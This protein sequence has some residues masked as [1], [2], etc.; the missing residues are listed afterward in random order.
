MN[1][2]KFVQLKSFGGRLLFLFT[3]LVL[4]IS[5]VF[6]EV[7]ES[8]FGAIRE[9]PTDTDPIGVG[10]EPPPYEAPAG[11]FTWSMEKR[12]GV[13]RDRDGMIDYHWD[14]NSM[15][16]DPTYVYP[17]SWN[18]TFDG[19]Q[20]ENDHLN[21]AAPEYTYTWLLDGQPMTHLNRCFLTKVF[22]DKAPHT[23]RLSVLDG[24]GDPLVFRN[25]QTY[26]EQPVQIKDYF[27]VSI[28]DSLASG[29]G[30]PDIPQVVDPGFFGIGWT[31]ISPPYWQDERC[32]RSAF[33]SHALAAMALEAAD[34]H[35]S[36]T[37]ISF[38]CSG[39]TIGTYHYDE[40][41]P[42]KFAGVGMLVPYR[43]E[44]TDIPY[45]TTYENYI[46]SQMDQLQ[47][48]LVPPDGQ[49]SRQIDALLISAGGNDIHFPQMVEACMWNL[50]CWNNP[51]VLAHEDP[52]QSQGWSLY[53]LVDR[54]LKR[55]EYGWPVHNMPDNYDALGEEIN[56][57]DPKP[58]NVYITQYPEYTI[59]NT[60]NG[61]HCRMLDDIVWP[62]PYFAVASNEAAVASHF[63][64]KGLN[65][66]IL[67]AVNRYKN[68]YTAINWQFVDGLYE[69]VVQPGV[70]TGTPGLFAGPVGGEGHGYCADDNWI[71]RAD[72]SELLQG[73]VNLRNKTKGTMHPNYA[74]QQAIK[75][76]I[77]Y[78]MMPDLT[79]QSPQE[80]PTFSFS[81]SS[82]GLTSRAGQNGWYINSRDSYGVTYPMV[83]AQAV[84]QSTTTLNGA[85][86]LV[87]DLVGCTGSV[88]CT[89]TPSADGKQVTYA[90]TISASGTYRFQF[91]AQDPSGQVSFMQKEIKVDLEDP[92]LATPIGPFQ[93]EE[94]GSVGLSASVVTN[95]DG[96][97]LN[98]DVVVDFN[99]DL[100]YDGIFETTD[101]QPSFS[102][103]DVDGPENR[104]I[105]VQVVDRAGRTATRLVQ[106]T[107]SNG[108]PTAAINA[109][110]ATSPEG[111]AINLTSSVTDPGVDDTFYYA[112]EVKKDGSNYANG[113]NADF[114]FTPVDNGSYQ[115]FLTVADDD[116][117]VATATSQTIAVTN[118]PPSLRDLS[119]PPSGVYEG[120]NFTLSG[121]I[122]EP[123]TADTL[124]LTID[125]GDGS[126]PEHLSLPAGST[127]FSRNHTY[128][129]DSPSG[130]AWDSYLI[131]LSIAD[132][133]GG[134]GTASTSAVVNNLAPSL[135]ISAPENGSLYPVNA[136][137]NL[138]ASLTD[139]SSL[140]TLTCSVNWDDGTT[141]YGT[142]AAGACTASHVYTTA[143]VYTI[144]MTGTDD[145]TGAATRSVMAVIYDP[146]AGFVT[147][148]GWID[149]P[150]GA[151]KADGNLAGKANFGFVSKY[152]KG[153]SVPTGNTAFQFDLAGM[154]FASQ[155]YEWLIV[156]QNGLN[157]QFKGSGLINGA[158]DPNGNAY[159]FMLWAGDGSPDTFRIRIW[160][161]DAAGEHD[162]YDNGVDQ[163][164]GGGNIVV[165]TSK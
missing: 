60:N 108:S 83:A 4:A 141:E 70:E 25:G 71:R 31:Q 18:V 116:D 41:D 74:G 162:V 164:I 93:V 27:I 68:A 46:P 36:V 37:F 69:Y 75:S 161:E 5:L 137:V 40:N 160:W 142:L 119:V 105:Q 6:I 120:V 106:V 89:I 58:L 26:V 140:D 53:Q 110:P 72:E 52:T 32:S 84:A 91:N 151:Y 125:W 113:A 7:P 14:S 104:F 130:T 157:A 80:P 8:A 158:T 86:I 155:S 62:N 153:T 1:N 61:D 42:L 112:W 133:D 43:G 94:G 64:I 144:E 47:D 143:G 28:G 23:V 134:V 12:F 51:L 73:P 63:V 145:D 115:V 117:G 92:V 111:T 48:A 24:N 9:D 49:D 10:D 107:V 87:N 132:D 149:S 159:K 150:A 122:T 148:G 99:W 21:P 165:H 81:Y 154:A 56:A 17:T 97:P 20:T 55:G 54:A 128:A 138:S 98:D 121:N 66:E 156:N 123:G 45:S 19:C 152:Q 124:A 15:T 101:E 163:P 44:I 3:A 35:S 109:A 59:G 103:A 139:P 76:R 82:A 34:P 33:S 85:S 118:V 16:Y 13:D 100:D 50:D 126:T 90:I 29:Q 39:A 114:S 88:A 65:D 127:S 146:S 77:L 2:H 38:A 136:A 78:Y 11:G 67:A 95:A 22:D 102:A 131:A 57:I 79:G 135:T 129:D 147:G 30:N 96:V